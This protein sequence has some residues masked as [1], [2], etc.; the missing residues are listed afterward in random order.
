[1]VG[2]S[3]IDPLLVSGSED[4]S[5]RFWEKD[6][7][8]VLN[9]TSACLWLDVAVTDKFL[10]SGHLDGSVRL[11]SGKKK[12]LIYRFENLHD[13]SV[14]SLCINSLWKGFG[15]SSTI[16][17]VGK[18]HSIRLV[19]YRDFEVLD[20]AWPDEYINIKHS[21]ESISWGAFSQH[22]V[23]ASG[24]DKLLIYNLEKEQNDPKKSITKAKKFGT[25]N[26]SYSMSAK[27]DLKF[28]NNN[29]IK[30]KLSKVIDVAAN[31]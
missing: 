13:D 2:D 10:A 3:F 17:T 18:D 21:S 25:Y 28:I 11:W 26:R 4:R 1:M 23:V 24:N 5:I 14:T 20:E 12:A 29:P 16:T 31:K 15:V 9:C 19:D 7:T 22:I 30:L 8:K 27:D 6:S